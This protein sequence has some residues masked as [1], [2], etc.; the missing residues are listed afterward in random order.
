M[1]PVK[2]INHIMPWYALALRV[3]AGYDHGWLSK[4]GVWKAAGVCR[5]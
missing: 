5:N 2:E 1:Q 3:K 4:R